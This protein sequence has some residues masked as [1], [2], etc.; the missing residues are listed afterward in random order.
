MLRNDSVLVVSLIS[1]IDKQRL[2]K[3]EI[4][5]SSS[6]LEEIEEGIK[7]VLDFK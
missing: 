4:K 5:L 7:L 1:V 6:I 3:K 2:I